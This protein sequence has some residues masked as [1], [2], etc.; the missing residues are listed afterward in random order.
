MDSPDDCMGF[1]LGRFFVKERV[2]MPNI[3]VTDETKADLEKAAKLDHRTQDGEISYL[4]QKRLEELS[5]PSVNS[6]TDST[7]KS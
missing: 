1:N 7:K 6:D 2:K 4:L 3:Y 5:A